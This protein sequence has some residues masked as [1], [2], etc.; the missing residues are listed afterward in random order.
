MSE[1]PEMCGL[2]NPGTYGVLTL[3]FGHAD[4]GLVLGRDDLDM[5]RKSYF[6]KFR[7]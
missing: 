1:A 3:L 6:E 4:S 7:R 2:T 5:V